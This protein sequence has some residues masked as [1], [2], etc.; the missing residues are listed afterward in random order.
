MPTMKD[1]L[2][3]FFYGDKIKQLNQIKEEFIRS[4][5]VLP[6][7]L[8]SPNMMIKVMKEMD[9]HTLEVLIRQSQ[10][11]TGSMGT[12]NES[13][14]IATVQESRMMYTWDVITQNAI[15]LWTDYGFGSKLEVR[16]KD[17]A[18]Q[19][20]LD[21]FFHAEKN[22]CVLGQREVS[23]LSKEVLTDG[24]FFYV[25]YVSKGKTPTVRV[26]PTEQ[27]KE[28]ITDPDDASVP[29]L[30]K[31]EW[32]ATDGAQTTL[33]Y[34]DWRVGGD[35]Q[36]ALDKILLKRTEIP[37]LLADKK[38]Q[39]ESK[40]NAEANGHEVKEDEAAAFATDIFMMHIAHRKQN[41]RG[42]PLMTAGIPWSK[43][44]KNFLQ[45]RAAL[46]RTVAMIVD[47]YTVKGGSTAVE[48]M[49]QKMDSSNTSGTGGYETNPKPVAGSSLFKNE[50]VDFSRRPLTTGAGDAETDGAM[51]LR[52]AGQA[53]RM[54]P[55]YFGA[56]EAFRLATATAM[57]QPVLRAFNRYRR[58]W[59]SG[60]QDVATVVFIASG[61][62]FKD[63]SIIVVSDPLVQND[64]AQI[65][66]FTTAVT[67]MYD[68]QAITPEQ[69]TAVGLAIL[70][71]GLKAI[72][73]TDV[74]TI[75]E[76]EKP[77]ESVKTRKAK[78]VE[79]VIDPKFHKAFRKAIAETIKDE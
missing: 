77:K 57:E 71:A 60:W 6:A 19:I 39:A 24:E 5:E 53:A 64:I 44:Y 16:S 75:L 59:D 54:P 20:V 13:M 14:R 62:N 65:G 76:P 3:G 30:Y 69:M 56:G 48:A 78:V 68:R 31:R 55:H 38:A 40:E 46:A 42:W 23:D 18:A 63:T 2:A 43:A 32:S 58:F 35:D 37:P 50:A 9:S 79:T 15:D 45:D 12:T 51:L 47:D 25:F 21:E 70:G 27:I 17:P 36:A 52:Q 67:D 1:R 74:G 73:V 66:T 41:G 61:K 29:L 22:Q 10:A 33:Y 28:I 4:Y 7:A 72:G 34:R 49:R 26:I 11:I 8:Q